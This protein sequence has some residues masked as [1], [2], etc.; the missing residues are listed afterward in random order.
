MFCSAAFTS[1]NLFNAK[2][3]FDWHYITWLPFLL[4]E[5]INEYSDSKKMIFVFEDEFHKKIGRNLDLLLKT[6]KID[7]AFHRRLKEIY[8][9]EWA[10]T[11]RYKINLSKNANEKKEFLKYLYT[12]YDPFDKKYNDYF[13]RVFKIQSKANYISEG[14]MPGEYYGSKIW[15]ERDNVYNYVPPYLQ[16]MIAVY[17][18]TAMHDDEKFDYEYTRQIYENFKREYP[19]HPNMPWIDAIYTKLAQEHDVNY[20]NTFGKFNTN[21]NLIQNKNSYNY[22][23]L[24]EVIQKN[25]QG[26]NVLVA[27]WANWCGACIPQ[28]LQHHNLKAFLDKE[29]IELLYVT[30]DSQVNSGNWLR[31]IRKRNLDSWHYFP[32]MDKHPLIHEI[33]GFEKDTDLPRYL[34]LDKNGNVILNKTLLPTEK[35]KMYLQIKNAI[36]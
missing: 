15:P 8:Q 19:D 24:K 16:P 26:K 30:L 11:M 18:I 31:N 17:Q 6:K 13:E 22:R 36:K 5:R 28:L 3:Y 29:N 25:F 10:G 35:E 14:W 1:G 7:S 20:V 34:L 12:K 2:K 9:F 33:A 32:P 23:D 4:A 21:T 27:I